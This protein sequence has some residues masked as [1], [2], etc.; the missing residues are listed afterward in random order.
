[1]S[2]SAVVRNANRLP[3]TE[4]SKLK[5]SL[6]LKGHKH[7]EDRKKP[8]H[9]SF[10]GITLKTCVICNTLFWARGPDRKQQKT[11]SK[12]CASTNRSM[13]RV[14]KTHI[15]FIEPITGRVI[16]LQSN[17]E[18][19]IAEFMN[20]I[21]IIWSR[22]SKRIKWNDG[23]K[24]RTYLPDFY[25]PLFDL[26]LDVKNPIGIIQQQVKITAVS[27]IIKLVVLELDPMKRYLEA[28]SRFELDS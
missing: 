17:W 14:R 22:P 27:K 16:D 13:N 21:G 8:E 4:E 18:K 2:C 12:D 3:R 24:D 25:L 10:T 5:T 19:S 28:L 7:A 23:V 6:A 20:D 1:M 11:C 9:Y 15:P 26:Y